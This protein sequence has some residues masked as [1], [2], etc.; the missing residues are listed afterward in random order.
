MQVQWY[1][2]PTVLASNTTHTKHN[3]LFS[4]SYDLSFLFLV[5]LLYVCP[6]L[7]ARLDGHLGLPKTTAASMA[8][9]AFTAGSSVLMQ[10]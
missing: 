6:Y 1:G 10:T 9:P 8:T 2:V 4:T 3:E 5:A 7:N